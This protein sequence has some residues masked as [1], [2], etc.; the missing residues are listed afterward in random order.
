MKIKYDKDKF[1]EAF[2]DAKWEES[3]PLED[4]HVVNHWP[5]CRK[6]CPH[7]VHFNVPHDWFQTNLQHQKHYSEGGKIF[8]EC[9]SLLGRVVMVLNFATL[10][11]WLSGHKSDFHSL[12]QL[13]VF[14][15][16]FG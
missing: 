11:V 4:K 12:K 13:K 1:V 3:F 9:C 10:S 8:F 6:K 7:V 14:V 2:L 16:S 5:P 15:F